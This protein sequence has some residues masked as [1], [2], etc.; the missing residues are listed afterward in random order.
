MTRKT[1]VLGAG[2]LSAC[3]VA[4][5]CGSPP[6][7][8][9]PPV[10]L[11]EPRAASAATGTEV[12][13]APGPVVPPSFGKDDGKDAGPS[14]K[15]GGSLADAGWEAPSDAGTLRT[16]P[17]LDDTDAVARAFR[18]ANAALDKAYAEFVKKAQVAPS[19]TGAWTRSAPSVVKGNSKVGW[20]V[21]FSSFPPAGFSHEALVHVGPKGDVTVKKAVASFSPD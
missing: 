21:T 11:P 20:D 1:A 15:D 19:H 9:V 12:S 16:G 10:A 4:L 13:E 8:P 7:P 3:F 2:C 5:A 6:A 18:P 14:A 17:V